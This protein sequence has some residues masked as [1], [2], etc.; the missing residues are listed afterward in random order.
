M[1]FRCQGSDWQENTLG[2][3]QELP[4]GE[5]RDMQQALCAPL[6]CFAFGLE[7]IVSFLGA[8]ALHSFLI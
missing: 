2:Q 7:S 8:R 6:R 5:E 1:A 4:L 3:E